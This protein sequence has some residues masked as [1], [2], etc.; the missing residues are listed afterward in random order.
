M[1]AQAETGTPVASS[2]MSTPKILF[3]AQRLH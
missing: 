1:P 3:M 2:K